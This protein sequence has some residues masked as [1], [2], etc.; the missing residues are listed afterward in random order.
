MLN[1]SE[2]LGSVSSQNVLSDESK[3]MNGMLELFRYKTWA[4]LRLIEYC[5]GLGD[6]HLD[7]TTPGTYGTIRETLR[8]LVDS[9]E[10][11]LSILTRERFPS[12]AAAAAFVRSPDRLPEGPVPLD[13]LAERIRRMGPRWE[14]IAQD[15]DHAGRDVTTTDGWHLPGALI[16]AQTIQHAGEHRSQVMSILGS[17]G[18]ELPGPNDLDGWGYAEALGLMK[19][20]PAT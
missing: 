14:A 18:L 16:L 15:A 13:E 1:A 12:K 5:Q 7:A 9:E 19:E 3:F 6:E 4:T 11:Y 8:H 2:I 10:G 17:R 20:L